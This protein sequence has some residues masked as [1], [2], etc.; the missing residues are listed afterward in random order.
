MGKAFDDVGLSMSAV[1]CPSVFRIFSLIYIGKTYLP[2]KKN[3]QKEKAIPEQV[4]S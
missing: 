4:A 2:K 3:P 1:L